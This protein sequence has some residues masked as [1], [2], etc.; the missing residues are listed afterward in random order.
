MIIK[1]LNH[2][3]RSEYWEFLHKFYL[4][5]SLWME[6]KIVLKISKIFQLKV[7]FVSYYF[8]EEWCIQYDWFQWYSYSVISRVK[9]KYY[10]RFGPHV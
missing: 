4:Y 5:C 2:I 6:N 1:F 7:P 8:L 10:K 3:K 9:K